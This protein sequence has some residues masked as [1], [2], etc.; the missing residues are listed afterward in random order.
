[1]K[2]TGHFFL[3]LQYQRFDNSLNKATP[4]QAIASD[5]PWGSLPPEFQSDID[6][7]INISSSKNSTAL[8]CFF[9]GSKYLKYD[10]KKAQPVGQSAEISE[11]WPCKYPA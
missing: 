1:M 9:K 8:L 7:V 3:N 2:L 4:P 10:I 11:G 6:D 5:F